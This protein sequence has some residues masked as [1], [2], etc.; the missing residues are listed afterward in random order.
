MLI[1]RVILQ[2]LDADK[3]NDLVKWVFEQTNIILEPLKGLVQE[4]ILIGNMQFEF[5]PLVALIF[6]IVIAY[7]IK[8]MIKTFS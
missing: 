2:I 4:Y 7:I 6:L 1:A 5:L 8:E 3:S